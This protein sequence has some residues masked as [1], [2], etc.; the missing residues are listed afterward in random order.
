MRGEGDPGVSCETMRRARAH[1]QQ[2]NRHGPGNVRG[3]FAAH[4]EGEP[5]LDPLSKVET[6]SGAQPPGKGAT[7]AA[8]VTLL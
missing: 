2:R 6:H 5:R 4:H 3:R 1:A 7:T 8:P